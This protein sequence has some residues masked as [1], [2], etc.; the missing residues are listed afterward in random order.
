MRHIFLAGHGSEGADGWRLSI[1]P[2]EKGDQGDLIGEWG[3]FL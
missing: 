3:G 2:L 1:P